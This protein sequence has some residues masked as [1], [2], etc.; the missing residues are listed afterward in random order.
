M[1]KKILHKPIFT[2]TNNHDKTKGTPPFIKSNDGDQ[3]C[4]Y[5]ENEYREQ[6]IFV[7]DYTAHKGTL[8]MSEKGWEHPFEVLDGKTS[9]V[10]LGYYEKI[11]LKACV[12][13]ALGVEARRESHRKLIA[14]Q[15][16]P[17]KPP[18]I[19]SF[20]PREDF[21]VHM[22]HLYDA[23]AHIEGLSKCSKE[24]F[25]SGWTGLRDLLE[26]FEIKYK[27]KLEGTDG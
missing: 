11:W 16:Q 24:E 22:E 12:N 3:Y 9:G 17:P 25:V 7:Y 19:S 26:K 5:F 2:A 21:K 27:D 15:N 1:P 8:W 14:E 6:L 10:G 13:V 20:M 4:A 18:V 23:T